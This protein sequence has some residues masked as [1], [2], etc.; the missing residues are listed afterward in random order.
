MYGRFWLKDVLAGGGG[1]KECVGGRACTGA[2]C[3]A[4]VVMG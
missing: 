4:I 2:H 3:A 1:G